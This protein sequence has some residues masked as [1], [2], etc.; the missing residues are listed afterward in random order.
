MIYISVGMNHY[1]TLN[2]A[3]IITRHIK[4]D[5]TQCSAG[6]HPLMLSDSY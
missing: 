5:Y 6:L 4:M 3:I 2:S 1:Q